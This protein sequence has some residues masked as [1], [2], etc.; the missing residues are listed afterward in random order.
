MEW[1]VKKVIA[2]EGDNKYDEK[3][4]KKVAEKT[5]QKYGSER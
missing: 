1:V 2:M 4:P 5:S 3:R